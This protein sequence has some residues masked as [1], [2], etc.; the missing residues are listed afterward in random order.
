MS[1]ARLYLDF[2]VLYY[3][4]FEFYVCRLPLGGGVPGLVCLERA[5]VYEQ[6]DLFFV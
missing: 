1:G 6:H 2:F 3:V 4:F 5:V